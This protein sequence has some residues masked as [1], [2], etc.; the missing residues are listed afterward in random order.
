MKILTLDLKFL[1]EE[2]PLKT[3]AL[4]EL[5]PNTGAGNSK[6]LSTLERVHKVEGNKDDLIS[7][8]LYL[9][10]ISNDHVISECGPGIGK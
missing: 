2:P 7:S 1:R 6:C 8:S 5:L 10:W 3:A 9:S 4:D